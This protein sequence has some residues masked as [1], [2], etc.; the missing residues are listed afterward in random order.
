MYFCMF[1]VVSVLMVKNLC[2]QTTIINA[3]FSFEEQIT[4]SRQPTRIPFGID[5]HIQRRLYKFKACDDN[6]KCN[7]NKPPEG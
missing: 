2:F 5:N 4:L 1:E 7:E 6:F 3:L